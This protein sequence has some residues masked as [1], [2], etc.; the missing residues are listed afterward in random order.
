MKI[1][2]IGQKFDGGSGKGVFEYSRELYKNLEKIN[3]DVEKIETGSYFLFRNVFGRLFNNTIISF[4][5]SI[6]IKSEINH[7]MIPEICSGCIFKRPSIVTIHDLIPLVT[8]ERGRI[9]SFYFK[10]MIRIALKANHIIVVSNSTKQDLM[11]LFK[12]SSEKISLIYEGVDNSKYYPRKMK[13]KGNKFTIGYIGGLSKR[14]NVDFIL[15]LAKE[16]KN[17]KKILFK[18]AGKGPEK[19]RLEKLSKNMNLNNVKFVGFVPEE[20]LNKFYNSLDL[21][22]FPSFYEGFGLPVLEA[23]ACGAP[24]I[25]SNK[26]A[27]PE[28]V[29]N[30][31][32]I[33]DIENLEKSARRIREIIKDEKLLKGL[34]EKGI[35]RSKKFNWNSC[36]KNHLKIYRRVYEKNI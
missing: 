27:L 36:V 4:L 16:F 12:I 33:I 31:G 28:I 22:I 1:S 9:F 32:I 15:K 11:N 3:K 35:K 25:V 23:M 10:L 14:K 17:N 2:L 6:R 21:F 19:T 8:D 24:V 13:E 20:N 5:K 29:N 18:I 34:R 26:G 30:A 7:F